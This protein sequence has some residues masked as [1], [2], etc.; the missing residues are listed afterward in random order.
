[1]LLFASLLV[2]IVTAGTIWTVL[3]SDCEHSEEFIY[4]GTIRVGMVHGACGSC[5]KIVS[6]NWRP[7]EGDNPPTPV[8][9]AWDPMRSRSV[10]VYKCPHCEDHFIKIENVREEL[11]NCAKCHMGNVELIQGPS[12]D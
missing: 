5:R 7:R 3:C 4:G 1:M 9:S 2:T 8:A 10:S 6:L 11:K 12:A